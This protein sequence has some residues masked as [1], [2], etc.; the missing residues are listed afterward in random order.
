L[1][2]VLKLVF[3]EVVLQVGQENDAVCGEFL[4]DFWGFD[5]D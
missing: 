1:V 5:V 4:E 2:A 3:L